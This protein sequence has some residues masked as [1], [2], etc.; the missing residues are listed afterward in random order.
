MLAMG[1]FRVSIQAGTWGMEITRR[2]GNHPSQHRLARIRRRQRAEN[3]IKLCT[4]VL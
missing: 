3:E 2:F 1:I 4:V